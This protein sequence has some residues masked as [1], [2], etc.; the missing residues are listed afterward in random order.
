MVARNHAR[1]VLLLDDVS[2]ELDEQRADLLF[3][4]LKQFDGQVF[5]TTTHERHIPLDSSAKIWRIEAGQVLDGD[6]R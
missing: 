6:M 2:S 5:L 4:Y 1:P 3:N